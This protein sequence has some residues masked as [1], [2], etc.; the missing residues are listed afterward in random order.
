MADVAYFSIGQ[1]NRVCYFYV[2][3]AFLASKGSYYSEFISMKFLDT[4]L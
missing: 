4:S 2:F 3:H 1:Y